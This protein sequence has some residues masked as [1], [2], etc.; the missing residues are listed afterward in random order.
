[1]KSWMIIFILVLLVS[2]SFAQSIEDQISINDLTKEIKNLNRENKI[3]TNKLDSIRTELEVNRQLFQ[4]DKERAMATLEYASKIVDW[5]GLI[6]AILGVL[7]IL[8]GFIVGYFGFR[9]VRS[10]H[11]IR[12]R[13]NKSL[14]FIQ[15]EINEIQHT[16]KN[17]VNII[18]W[19]TEGWNNYLSG[20]YESAEHLFNKI[21]EIRA[22]DY[23]TC[24]RLAKI[25]SSMSNYHKATKEFEQAIKINP[26]LSDAYFGL[27]W[28]YKHQKEYDKAIEAYQKGLKITYGFYGL[29]GLSHVY[30]EASKFKEA[31]EC[32]IK[33]IKE[34]PNSGS[35][36]PLANIFLLESDYAKAGEYYQKTIEYTDNEMIIEPAYFWA[37][38]NKVGAEIGLN[39]IDLAKDS[40]KMALSK[41]AGL[42][43]LKNMLFQFEFM[44]KTNKIS[45]EINY[46]IDVLKSEIEIR[47]PKEWE[48]FPKVAKIKLE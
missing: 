19:S 28:N 8:I 30:M 10:F 27:G 20:N 45:N 1:M 13:M 36:F 15:K 21:K 48:Q 23:E 40:L 3:L 32:F 42:E 25:Y 4:A 37:Y 22:D 6:L 18:H 14:K 17:I 16:S 33:S 5:S 46:F 39:K 24:Y 47:E 31:K 11:R 35:S 44:K 41:N 38:Y 43:I 7:F 34:K 26:N 2:I 29:C 9:E 12:R